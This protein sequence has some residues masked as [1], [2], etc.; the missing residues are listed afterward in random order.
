MSHRAD[1]QEQYISMPI[2]GCINIFA[3]YTWTSLSK[4]QEELNNFEQGNFR[5]AKTESGIWNVRFW[6]SWIPRTS[7]LG[8]L[9]LGERPQENLNKINSITCKSSGWVVSYKSLIFNFTVIT[10][11]EVTQN[12][13]RPTW[14]E[15]NIP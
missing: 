7:M 2:L 6:H 1:K 4:R 13:H 9:E 5:S 12:N 15:L 3:R 14:L 8:D 11:T 10:Q